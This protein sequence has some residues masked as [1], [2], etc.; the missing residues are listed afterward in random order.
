MFYAV[1][2]RIELCRFFI[3]FFAQYPQGYHTRQDVGTINGRK[4]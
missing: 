3:S 1:H 2:T 4:K